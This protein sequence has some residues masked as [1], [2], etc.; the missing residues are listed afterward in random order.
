M[1]KQELRDIICETLGFDKIPNIIETQIHRF[2]M[3]LGLTYKE[4]A[5]AVVYFYGIKKNEYQSAYGIGVVANIYPESNR[6]Y[7]KL[8]RQREEQLKSVEEAKKHSNIIL[9]VKQIPK[10]KTRKTI[11]IEKLKIDD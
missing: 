8:K 10:R 11:D 7:E 5:R 9:E 3:E 2:T 6:Y 1:K 4:V